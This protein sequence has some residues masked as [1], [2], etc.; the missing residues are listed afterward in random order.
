M[1]S[2]HQL[3]LEK[4][5]HAYKNHINIKSEKFSTPKGQDQMQRSYKSSCMQYTLA[6][7]ENEW[8]RVLHLRIKLQDKL[9]LVPFPSYASLAFKAQQNP[10]E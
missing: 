4:D 10:H 9:L 6:R 1:V 2:S 3:K 8:C 7:R 5:K